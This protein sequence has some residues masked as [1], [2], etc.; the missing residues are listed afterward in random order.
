MYIETSLF[1]S[2]SNLIKKTFIKIIKKLELIM[3]YISLLKIQCHKIFKINIYIY[4]FKLITNLKK[5]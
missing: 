1:K 3:L 2:Y 5:T 4:L